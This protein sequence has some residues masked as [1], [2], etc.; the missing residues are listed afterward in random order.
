M[1]QMVH[2]ARLTCPDIP[3]DTPP[4]VSN[5]SQYRKFIKDDQTSWA[6]EAGWLVE[7]QA[8]G[9]TVHVAI[10]D[11][12]DPRAMYPDEP[13]YLYLQRLRP[14]PEWV[15]IPI[16]IVQDIVL[17]HPNWQDLLPLN[18]S[19]CPVTNGKN[20]SRRL[21]QVSP[22]GSNSGSSVSPSPSASPSPSPS[23]APST[24]PPSII[25]A[26]SGN[27][28]RCGYRGNASPDA[29]VSIVELGPDRTVVHE[30]QI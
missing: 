2:S 29:Q 21:R 18:I 7:E 23:P 14:N 10:H 6:G 16:E 15:L 8:F 13:R 26:E 17:G 28:V 22:T 27:T 4:G 25:K 19:T 20:S 12:L 9:G 24:P 5:G 3:D 1:H 30:W 11:R